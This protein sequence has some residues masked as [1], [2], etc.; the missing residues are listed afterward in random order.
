MSQKTVGE[1]GRAEA[2]ERAERAGKISN[3]G[4]SLGFF[5]KCP[6]FLFVD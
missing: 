1:L 3:N 4:T 2:A 5:Q 6:N